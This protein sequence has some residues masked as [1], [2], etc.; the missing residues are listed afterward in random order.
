[1][2][3]PSGIA[4]AQQVA[5]PSPIWSRAPEA[6][7]PLSQE[8]AQLG[9]FLSKPGHLL[10]LMLRLVEEHRDQFLIAYGLDISARRARHQVESARR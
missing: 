2:E 8:H 6:R 4:Q 7:Q 1:M 10:V 5:E 9:Q 3:D